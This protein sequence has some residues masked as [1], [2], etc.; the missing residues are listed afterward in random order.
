VLPQG[1]AKAS[2]ASRPRSRHPPRPR[3]RHAPRPLRTD[4]AQSSQQEMT[5]LPDT[6]RARLPLGKRGAFAALLTDLWVGS[7]WEDGFVSAEAEHGERD[8]G[9]G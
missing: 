1:Q 8:Q 3:G 2:R 4:Q 5:R 9:V 7:A 6:D